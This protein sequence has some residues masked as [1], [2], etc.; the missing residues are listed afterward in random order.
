MLG[1][2]IIVVQ[3]PRLFDGILDD[4]LGLGGLGQLAHGYHVG[5]AFYEFFYLQTQLL[6]IHIK[7]F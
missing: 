5:P 6:N 1:A 2:H 3:C 4:L 7:I